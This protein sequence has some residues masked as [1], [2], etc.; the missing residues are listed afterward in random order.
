[1]N[2]NFSGSLLYLCT[3]LGSFLSS[4]LLSRF[5]HKKCLIVTNVPC[6]ISLIM[7]GYAENVFTLYVCSILM[8]LSIGFTT[9]PCFSYTGEICEPKLRGTLCSAINVFYYAGSL[10]FTVIYGITKQWRLT[11]LISAI[12]PILNIFILLMVTTQFISSAEIYFKSL[13]FLFP[14]FLDTW[15]SNVASYQR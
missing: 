9:G 1:M 4:L 6:L 12:F 10:V 11:L 13:F 14:P 3:P 5:G 7:L 2:K 15:F 8:G